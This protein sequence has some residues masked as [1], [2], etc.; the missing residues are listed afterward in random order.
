[1]M[2]LWPFYIALAAYL[3]FIAVNLGIGFR[4]SKTPIRDFCVRHCFGMIFVAIA[5]Q[6]GGLYWDTTISARVIDTLI[7]CSYFFFFHYSVGVQLFSVAQRS[8]STNLLV[9]LLK[10]GGKSEL[11]AL[12]KSYGGGNSVGH[13]TQSRLAQMEEWEWIRAGKTEVFI[14]E[15]GRIR[16]WIADGLL[17]LF[18]LD[19]L[20]VEGKE[21]R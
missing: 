1:M 18:S 14:T 11:E 16:L 2:R 4:H 7:G 8:V 3:I 17:G 21:D 13:V 20:G 5:L 19:P 15:K 9:S 10:D 12:K 6:A